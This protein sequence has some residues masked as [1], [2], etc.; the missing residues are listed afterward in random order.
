MTQ[1]IG[2]SISLRCTGGVLIAFA[3]AGAIVL[4]VGPKDYPNLHTILD[5]GTA[6]L[7]AVLVLLL[8]DM[9]SRSGER[10]YTWLATAF[11]VTSGLEM[12]HVLVTVE[13]SGPLSGIADSE[14]FLRPATWPPAAH[15]LPLAIGVALWLMRRGAAGRLGYAACVAGMGA[16]LFVAFQHLPTYAQA[17]LGITRPALILAPLLWLAVGLAAWRWR[18]SDRLLRPLA[19][20]AAVLFLGNLAML[21]SAAPA[22]G[23]AMAAHLGKIAG[24]LV[25]LL[26]VMQMASLDMVERRRAEAALARLNHEL[27]RRIGERWR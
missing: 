3:L 19:W 6:L 4:A 7:S 21:Y 25:L 15:L 24:Y 2:R 11:A 26:S 12:L 23:P 16:A 1:P 14:S 5:T 10:L 22:D 17:H 20:T 13:W 8:W 18:A 9:G 27:D